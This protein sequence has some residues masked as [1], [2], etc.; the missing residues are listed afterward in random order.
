MAHTKFDPRSPYRWASPD[1]RGQAEER[2]RNARAQAPAPVQVQASAPVHGPVHKPVVNPQQVARPI[3]KTG[4]GS[5]LVTAAV[6]LAALG[7]L[8]VL[9]I[10]AMVVASV[11][12]IIGMCMLIRAIAF[13][14]NKTTTPP[15]SSTSFHSKGSPKADSCQPSLGS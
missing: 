14:P 4:V 15:S 13:W 3:I 11:C 10:T 8:A 12:G 9:P 7:A 5:V 6:S 2:L 1:A